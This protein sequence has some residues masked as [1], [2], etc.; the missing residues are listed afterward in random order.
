MLP[1]SIMQAALWTSWGSL[2]HPNAGDTSYSL[3]RSGQRLSLNSAEVSPCSHKPAAHKLRCTCRLHGNDQAAAAGSILPHLE[4]EVTEELSDTPEDSASPNAGD[5]A[6]VGQV[7]KMSTDNF[8]SIGPR[9]T[10]SGADWQS[11][12]PADVKEVHRSST[13]TAWMLI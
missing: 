9:R 11:D 3:A 2:E 5:R 12:K 7:M 10:G 13:P 1:G 4:R 6:Y 8:A